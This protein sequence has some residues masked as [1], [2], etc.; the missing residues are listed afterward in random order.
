MNKFRTAH[1]G[2][3]SMALAPDGQTL[4]VG[5]NQELCL[6]QLPAGE[7]VRT[8]P[9]KGSAAVWGLAFSPDGKELAGCDTGSV[10]VWTL[11]T[12]RGRQLPFTP[13]YATANVDVRYSPNG[14]TLVCVGPVLARWRVR[15][16][17]ELPAWD[18]GTDLM[19]RAVAFSPDGATLAI[20]SAAQAQKG[21]AFRAAVRLLDSES[22]QSKGELQ[23]RGYP[24]E[25]LSFSADG[26]RIAGTGGPYLRVWDLDA[27]RELAQL[28]PPDKQRGTARMENARF[29]PDGKW[30]AAT[31]DLSVHVWHAETLR[32]AHSYR[33]DVGSI[34]RF[35]FSP[36]GLTGIA[37]SRD[38]EVVVWDVE[39]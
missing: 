32:V 1:E 13:R 12:G 15:G 6:Y 39:G 22:G 21:T 33:W 36:D 11:A 31:Y 28:E 37:A 10:W 19:T 23:W 17:K 4:A 9:L 7:R 14:K 20:C 24:A 2:L 30:L 26:R 38:G 25:S 34:Q 3:D 8:I 29:S 27:G 18:L 35:E 5:H 16:K